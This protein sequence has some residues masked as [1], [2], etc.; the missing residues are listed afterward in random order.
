MGSTMGNDEEFAAVT[1]ELKAG[2]LTPV[3]DSVLD[4]EN[5]RDGFERMAAGQQFGKIVV[6]V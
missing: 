1:D 6:R 4:L 5:G 3:I 2:R